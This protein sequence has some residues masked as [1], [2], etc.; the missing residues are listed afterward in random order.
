MW[1]TVQ[2]VLCSKYRLIYMKKVTAIIYIFLLL[3]DFD[4]VPHLTQINKLTALF[5]ILVILL[6]WLINISPTELREWSQSSSER[7]ISGVPQ[8]KYHKALISEFSFFLYL[9]TFMNYHI[10]L[11]IFV[12]SKL[13]T[14]FS[15][16][17]WIY[18][19]YSE[20]I[21]SFERVCKKL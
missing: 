4:N 13:L 6:I 1:A 20:T 19:F 9:F 15:I 18:R 3:L 12:S 7:N 17:Q 21:V 16:V 8:G 2:Q 10:C 14:F 5:N 11:I